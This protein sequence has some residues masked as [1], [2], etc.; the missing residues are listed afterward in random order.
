MAHFNKEPADNDLLDEI[1]RATVTYKKFLSNIRVTHKNFQQNYI[2]ILNLIYTIYICGGTL[3]QQEI[4]D[5]ETITEYR[6][7]FLDDAMIC[8]R[9]FELLEVGFDSNKTIAYFFQS[10]TFLSKF[11]TKYV[12]HYDILREITYYPEAPPINLDMID[13]MID[14][15]KVDMT[16]EQLMEYINHPQADLN[17][18]L[19]LTR[20]RPIDLS[21]DIYRRIIVYGSFDSFKVAISGGAIQLDESV[22][23]MC[24]YMEVSQKNMKMRYVLDNKIVPTKK[25]FDQIIKMVGGPKREMKFCNQSPTHH[26]LVE[27]II[28]YGYCPTYEDVLIALNNGV[29][30]SRIER[31]NITFDKEYTRWSVDNNYNPYKVPNMIPDVNCLVE[32]CKKGGNLSA[33]K[34]MINSFNL[35][36]NTECLRAAC[37]NKSSMQI[38]RLLIQYG[39]VPDIECIHNMAVA[40]NSRALIL[41]IDEYKKNNVPKIIE[42]PNTINGNVERLE[43][44]ENGHTIEETIQKNS[45]KVGND[46]NDNNDNNDK[47]DKNDNNDN[48][49]K[50]KKEQ[51][52]SDPANN[53]DPTNVPITF[54]PTQDIAG[55][56]P[57][58]I[59]ALIN[60]DTGVLSFLDFR[61]KMVLYL[62]RQNAFSRTHIVLKKPYLFNAQ[63]T[64]QVRQINEWAYWLLTGDQSD[65]IDPVVVADERMIETRRERRKNASM[66]KNTK[67]KE[68][69]EETNKGTST[70][71]TKITVKKRTIL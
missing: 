51:R 49:D 69:D 24:C 17:L 25:V 57:Q 37:T 64:I 65:P 68:T 13:R 7:S 18:A 36:P 58:N 50:N 53:L 61:E 38:I 67:S 43:F 12:L 63:E 70:K 46:N 62:N 5:F 40:L 39:A 27:M 8:T 34:K 45:E 21:T 9:V 66:R 15:N 26:E 55:L 56:I 44:S 54:D 31:F 28:D 14:R 19:K 32:L 11:S 3:S 35:V 30:I 10:P 16:A 59:K 47:N 42:R 71:K 22:L 2:A 20:Y 1:K 4:M 33:I 60:V 23:M 41:V 48:N 52:Q 6:E 29:V